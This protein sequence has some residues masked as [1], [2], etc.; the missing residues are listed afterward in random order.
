VTKMK[1]KKLQFFVCYE[2]IPIIILFCAYEL[3][4]TKQIHP[5]F[6]I[7][8]NTSNFISLDCYNREYL[9]Y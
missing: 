6:T 3:H 1:K 8:N 7:F 2:I 5:V 9:W 4:S